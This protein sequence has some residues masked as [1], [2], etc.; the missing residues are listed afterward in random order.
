MKHLRVV[1]A[2]NKQPMYAEGNLLRSVM[3]YQMLSPTKGTLFDSSLPQA[4][5]KEIR[6]QR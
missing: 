4:S 3:N 1:V 5:V 6:Q 2:A